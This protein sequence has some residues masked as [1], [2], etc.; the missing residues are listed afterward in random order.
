MRILLFLLLL[1]AGVYFYRSWARRRT[2][3]RLLTSPLTDHQRAVIE[4]AAPI[5]RRVPPDL[6][7]KLEGKVNLFLQQIKFVGCNGLD[8]TEEMRLSIAAQAC[9][10]IVN[11]DTWYKNLLTVLV[12]PDAYRARRTEH[13]GHLVTEG[14]DTRLGES[15]Q[16]GPVVLSWPDVQEGAADD[17]DGRNVVFHEFAHQIDQL[18][19]E[20]DGIPILDKNHS[21][22]DWEDNF[23]DAYERHV[24]NI[25]SDRDTV[26]DP[27]G[28][29]S[30]AE[31][32]AVSVELFFENPLALKQDEP[33][34]Y[35]QLA[36]FFRLDPA[37]WG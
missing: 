37:N 17:T 4:E 15:W 20:A 25:E 8:V 6:L 32:L 3:A 18:S 36:T 1:G 35:E 23:V 34:V 31:F 10:L 7:D 13:D 5:F 24:R 30:R 14:E 21:Y 9:L 22:A 29:T 19:V 33:A 27:Y 12:Y 26:I 2:R 16:R 11:T 28:A